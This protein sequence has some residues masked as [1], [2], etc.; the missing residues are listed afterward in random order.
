LKAD[1]EGE[2]KKLAAFLEIEVVPE[3]WPA[4]L[5]HCHIDY[6]REL[7]MRNERMK[8]VFK[9][10]GATFINKG[11]NGR[12]RDLL[13]ADDLAKFAAVVAQNLTPE[14]ARWLETGRLPD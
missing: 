5:E 6:M 11:T 10:G 13:T 7:A 2:I 9:G 3:T 4:I 8:T 14:C 12:W 1:L